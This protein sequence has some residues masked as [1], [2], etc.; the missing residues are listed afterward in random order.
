MR[1]FGY[2]KHRDGKSAKRSYKVRVVDLDVRMRIS[3][4]HAPAE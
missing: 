3:T 1:P 4:D 2:F